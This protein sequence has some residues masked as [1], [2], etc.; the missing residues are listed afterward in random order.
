MHARYILETWKAAFIF[1]VPCA[2]SINQICL[3]LVCLLDRHEILDAI[4][5]KIYHFMN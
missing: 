2:P 1:Q 4:I 5:F 3:G